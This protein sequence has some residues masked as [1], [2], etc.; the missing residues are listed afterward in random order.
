VK[1]LGDKK[2]YIP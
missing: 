2:L 1:N